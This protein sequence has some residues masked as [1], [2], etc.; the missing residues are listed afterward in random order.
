MKCHS[1]RG[2]RI[3]TLFPLLF[4]LSANTSCAQ[5]VKY[6]EKLTM[7]RIRVGPEAPPSGE[8]LTFSDI[9]AGAVTHAVNISAVK[10]VRRDPTSESST[11]RRFFGP[12]FNSAQ[13]SEQTENSLGSGVFISEDGYV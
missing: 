6:K 10:V 4:L 7:C 8:Q 5:Q 2:F 9:A 1:Q 13:P 12:D 11:L 3:I